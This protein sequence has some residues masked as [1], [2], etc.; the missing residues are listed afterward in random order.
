MKS[1]PESGGPWVWVCYG[2]AAAGSLA[3]IAAG[4][5]GLPEAQG[6]RLAGIIGVALVLTLG[7]LALLLRRPRFDG[8]EPMQAKLEQLNN[9]VRALTEQAALSD[10]ARR[11]FN[12]RAE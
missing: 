5:S 3:L 7:P 6:L 1:N 12:R 2:L 9:A 10:D 4:W 11:V 8:S